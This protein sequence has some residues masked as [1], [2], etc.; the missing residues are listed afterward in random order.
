MADIVR[1]LEAAAPGTTVSHARYYTLALLTIVYALNF[2]DRTIFNVL[3]E[4]IKKEFQLS[5]T[6]LGLLAGFGFVL[7]YS[8]LGMPI[9]R[10]A[11]RTN[12][13]TIVALGLTFWSAMTALCGMAQNVTMLA[14]ARIGV[15]IGESA[16]TPASQSIIAD[17]FAKDERPRALGIFAIGTYLGVFLGYFF[18]G[19]VNQYFGWRAAFV[20]AGLPGLLIALLLWATVAEPVR[21]SDG[22]ERI[23]NEA[24]GP[25]FA[26]LF[27]QKSFVLVL[28]GFCLAGFTNYSTSVWIP[29]FMARVH[30]LTS[31][32]IGTYAGTFKGLFGIAGALLG[33]FVV[34][35]ISKDD[36]RWKV[37]APA[38]MSG[39]AGPIFVVCMLTSSF[40]VMVWTLGLFSVFVG[41]HLGPIFA[42]AQTIARTSMR[43]LAAATVLLTATCFGQGI[44]PLAVGYLNDVLKAAYGAEAVRY[45]LMIAALATVLAALFFGWAAQ[46]IRADIKRAAE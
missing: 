29:P 2:L 3:I 37:W 43:A 35:K 12:R 24:I 16:G 22:G 40:H 10:L 28:I 34:A 30:H 14:F 1:P 25:T 11:D 18:G 36:D 27:S 41:F 46:S 5:D 32:E 19:W 21:R 38:I 39:L 20:G 31:A 8:V 33:G 45:S 7:M 42:V 15:G 9:A 4:P 26:F 44:G 6:M 13:R 17:L 23:G